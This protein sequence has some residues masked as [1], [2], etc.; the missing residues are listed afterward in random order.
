MTEQRVERRLAAILAADVV[1]YSRLMGGDETGTLARLKTLRAE[2]LD[3]KTAE[4]GGRIVKTTGDGVLIEFPSA[5]N[6]VQ[7][8]FDVQREVAR[9][10]ATDPEDRRIEL[11]IGINI[12]DVIIDG[13]DIYG[14]GVNVAARLEE[15]AEPGGISVS[16]MVH[17]SVRNR[18]DVAFEDL[19]EQSFKNIADPVR[20]YRISFTPEKVT[21]DASVGSDA[22]FR[23]PAVAVLPFDNLSGDPEQEY[24]ADGLTED[25]I[26]ALS[27]W[28]S[29]P[30]IARNSTFAYKGTAPDI[31]KVGEELCARYASKA[32]C[33]R[34]EAEYGSPLSSSMPTLGTTSGPSAT[35]ATSKTFSLYRTRSPAKSRPSLNQPL[36]AL[37]TSAS[38]RARRAIWPLGNTVSGGSP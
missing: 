6:A 23:R 12:G 15:A 29:F 35:T 18:V 37:R 20:V 33:A 2:V 25:I 34:Q 9:Q 11:R 32:A 19:G 16:G 13:G 7:C 24:F 4:Y 38:G 1:G 36:R 14:D 22:A 27:S 26:T 8:A 31:R 28:R 17:E 3:P 21:R 10:G 5:V 30:V